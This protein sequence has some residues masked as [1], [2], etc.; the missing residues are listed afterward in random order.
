[1]KNPQGVSK[2]VRSMTVDGRLMAGNKAPVFTQGV[3]HVEVVLG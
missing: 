3:H 1:M 2:G